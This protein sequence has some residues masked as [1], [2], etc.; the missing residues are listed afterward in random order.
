MEAIQVLLDRYPGGARTKDSL[1]RL[2]LHY[3]CSH[4]APVGVVR[5][6]LKSFSG[7]A[8]IGDKNGWYAIHVACRVGESPEV[9]DELI[10]AYPD[11]IAERTKKGSTPLMCAHKHEGKAVGKEDKVASEC[12]VEMLE[13][14]MRAKGIDIDN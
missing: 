3:A 9:I 13:Q 2:P 5:Q 7:G 6:L 11:G 14:A 1:G 10:K 4:S 12:V 8:A